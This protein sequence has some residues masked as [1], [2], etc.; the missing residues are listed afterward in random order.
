MISGSAY[1]PGDIVE[2]LSGKT[3]EVLNTDAEGR[4]TLADSVYYATE[5]LK[6]NKVIDLATLTGACLIALGEFYTGAVTNND[7]FF[8]ELKI[9]SLKAGERVWQLPVDD[10]FRKLNK[11]SVADVK[12]T[13]GRLGGTI[14]AGLFIENFV[15]NDIP[16]IHLDIAGTAYLSNSERYLPKGATGVHVKTLFNLLNK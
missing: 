12:N 11:S 6:V 4:I 9:A 16:W 2:T 3:I 13:G 8:N 1:K 5:K 7:N 14:T 10:S 15:A